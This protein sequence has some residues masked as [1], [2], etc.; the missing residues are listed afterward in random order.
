M[1][2]D[3]ELD[4]LSLP[5]AASRLQ[6][7]RELAAARATLAMKEYVAETKLIEQLRVTTAVFSSQPAFSVNASPSAACAPWMGTPRANLGKSIQRLL[8][9][10]TNSGCTFLPQE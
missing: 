10:D 5:P 1:S 8:Q 6:L 9:M 3:Y 4:R 2:L 7:A